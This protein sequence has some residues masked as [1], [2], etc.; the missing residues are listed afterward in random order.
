MLDFRLL[1]PL[2]DHLEKE[3]DQSCVRE[4]CIPIF[5]LCSGCEILKDER[6]VFFRDF[7]DEIISS[8]RDVSSCPPSCRLILSDFVVLTEVSD[9]QTLTGFRKCEECRPSSVHFV[10]FLEYLFFPQCLGERIHH[11]EDIFLHLTFHFPCQFVGFHFCL[12]RIREDTRLM[13]G[14]GLIFPLFLSLSPFRRIVNFIYLFRG[15]ALLFFRLF[16]CDSR[17][18]LLLSCIRQFC[19]FLDGLRFWRTLSVANTCPDILFLRFRPL[20][21]LLS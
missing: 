4:S 13:R 19:T 14:I 15:F 17:D 1:G 10:E 3:F 12:Y 5:P 20:F 9:S 18:D 11:L 6:S 2:L 7:I 8:P 16:R 21:R